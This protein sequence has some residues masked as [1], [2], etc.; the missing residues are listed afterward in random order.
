MHKWGREG[1]TSK[2]TQCLLVGFSEPQFPDGSW[3]EATPSSLP[4][5]SFQ[6]GNWL[7]QGKQQRRQQRESDNKLK[8]TR[9]SPRNGVDIPPVLLYSTGQKQIT[10]E[11]RIVQ[12]YEYQEA[13]IME[14]H[15]RSHLPHQYAHIGVC[16]KKIGLRCCSIIISNLLK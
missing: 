7:R 5:G 1:F 10:Q 11:M 13:D 9:F 6:H 2:L 4:C 8:I 15:L 12:G 14:C 3:L 16:K